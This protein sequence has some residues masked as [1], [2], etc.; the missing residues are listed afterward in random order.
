VEA[1]SEA[2]AERR[3]QAGASVGEAE[4]WHPGAR[5]RRR[6]RRHRG[7]FRFSFSFTGAGGGRGA[8]EAARC[9]E[10]FFLSFSTETAAYN[11]ELRR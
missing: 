7:T 10:F 6:R 2:V 11:E 1:E 4:A 3:W 9:S 5:R 8:A